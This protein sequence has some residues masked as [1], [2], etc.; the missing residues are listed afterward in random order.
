MTVW[1]SP[2]VVSVVRKEERRVSSIPFRRT[3]WF[4]PVAVTLHNF[5]EAASMPKWISVHSSQLPLDP[6]RGFVWTGLLVVTLA[7]F[8]V[9]AL[10]ARE[11]EE[12]P[13]AYLLFGAISTMLLNVFIPHLPAT[14]FFGGYTPGVVTA[15][16][17]NLPL[18]SILLFQAVRDRWV[19]G[20][21]AIVYAPL[22]PVAVGG[23][24]AAAFALT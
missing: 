8:A 3:Q 22:V 13:W 21:K 4:F 15:V 23:S 17:I 1:A 24:I 12:S 14:L 19:S 11:G 2:P 5:E 16:L 7:A 10:S 6:G 20:R 9:T 18:M